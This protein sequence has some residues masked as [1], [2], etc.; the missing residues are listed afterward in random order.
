MTIQIHTTDFGEGICIC[1][2]VSDVNKVPLFG[3]PAIGNDAWYCYFPTAA[4]RW[5][6]RS[7]SKKYVKVKDAFPLI[8]NAFAWWKEA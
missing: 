5:E 6:N 8:A 2:T 7:L 4:N 1:T 3:V